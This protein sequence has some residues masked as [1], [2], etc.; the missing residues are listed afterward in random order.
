MALAAL[1][2]SDDKLGD[3]NARGLFGLGAAA[4]TELYVVNTA[5]AATDATAGGKFMAGVDLR[6]HPDGDD[7]FSGLNLLGANF[8]AQYTMNVATT[9]ATTVLYCVSFHSLISCDTR[10]S[11]TWKVSV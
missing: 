11:N 1:L 3:I 10:G 6:S 5:A 2:Q 9:L 8:L 4:G 7:V